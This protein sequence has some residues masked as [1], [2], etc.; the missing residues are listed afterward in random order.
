MTDEQRHFLA[1][2]LHKRGINPSGWLDSL[3]VPEAPRLIERLR[4]QSHGR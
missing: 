4:G 3:S 2:L 1:S